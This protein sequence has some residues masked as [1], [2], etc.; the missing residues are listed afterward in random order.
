MFGLMRRLKLS[1]NGQLTF[2][3]FALWI[4][5][6]NLTF[7]MQKNEKVRQKGRNN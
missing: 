5:P 3:Q 7:L 6:V 4:K 2:G 1:V